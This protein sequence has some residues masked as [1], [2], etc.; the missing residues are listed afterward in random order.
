MSARGPR[1][2]AACVGSADRRIVV[3]ALARKLRSEARS[4]GSPDRVKRAG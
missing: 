1:V 2:L 4:R 3:E